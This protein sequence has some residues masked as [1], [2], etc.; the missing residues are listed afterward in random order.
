MPQ[1]S[2]GKPDFESGDDKA[3]QFA[4]HLRALNRQFAK[5]RK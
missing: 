1:A 2:F 5:V 3:K 4:I